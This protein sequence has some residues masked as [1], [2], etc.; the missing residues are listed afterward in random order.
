WTSPSFTRLLGWQAPIERVDA[1][2]HVHPD[3]R[4]SLF[5]AVADLRQ[6]RRPFALL[7]VRVRHRD[8]RYLVTRQLLSDCRAD[9]AVN[10]IVVTFRDVTD[11]RRVVGELTDELRRYQ[12]LAENA[13]EVLV[14]AHAD[15]TIGHASATART[16]LGRDPDE[17][18]G[19]DIGILLHPDDRVLVEAALTHAEWSRDVSSVEARVLDAR[20]HERWVHVVA[21]CVPAHT[22]EPQFHVSLADISARRDAELAMAASEQRFRS[23]ASQ[24]RELVTVIDLNGFITY[25]SPSVQQVLGYEGTLVVGHHIT[26][27]LHAEEFDELVHRIV[28]ESTTEALRHRALHVDGTY[29]WL[30]TLARLIGDREDGRSAVMLSSRDITDRLELEQR[31]D[32]ERGLLAAILDSVHAG[33]VAVDRHGVVLE[34]N[35]AFCRMLGT[36]LV[37]GRPLLDYVSTH[38]L[39]DEHGEPVPVCDRPL[40]VALAGRSL[41]ERV[42]VVVQADGTRHE[43]IANSIALLDERGHIDGAV[44]TYE[45][46]TDLRGAQEELRRLATLD[47]LTGLPNRRQ[48]FVHLE[49]AMHRHVR[50]PE[51]LA[52]LFLDLD[53]FKP[54]NDTLGHDVG[55]EL[56][57]QA[58][59][60][61]SALARSSDVVARYGGDEFVVVA[62]HVA[63]RADA[64]ALAR[65]IEAV[66]ALPFELGPATVSIGCSVGVTL[67]TDGT[68]PDELLACADQAMYERKKDRK[69]RAGLEAEPSRALASQL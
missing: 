58:A 62:E 1:P 15:R 67:G 35:Q 48:L 2:H 59:S 42:F 50:T 64:S 4:A 40:E 28:D 22:G 55:D 39:L 60:R 43:V 8:G 27:Y 10:G 32:R 33:V 30:E 21:R 19:V 23:L 13:S 31:L 47:P 46:V 18:T 14:M 61:I 69:D 25:V 11:H 41:A 7:D 66:L 49:E 26:R 54:V 20:G 65:R 51:R 56:L 68:T 29:R 36:E 6:R 53:G 34:A 38:E 5:A 45:D 16:V 63:S 12:F 37:S 44:L 9:P 52:L 57:R 24:T 17:L 3:D